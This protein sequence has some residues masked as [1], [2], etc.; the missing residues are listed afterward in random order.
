MALVDQPAHVSSVIETLTYDTSM[1][2]TKEKSSTSKA[3]MRAFSKL[4]KC[5]QLQNMLAHLGSPHLEA[6]C[7]SQAYEY[8]ILN[9]M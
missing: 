7:I 1:I 8:E 5:V 6:L 4:E 9:V 3:L 2:W